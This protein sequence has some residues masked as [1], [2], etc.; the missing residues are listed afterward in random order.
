MIIRDK[1]EL[2]TCKKLYETLNNFFSSFS[3]KNFNVN[4]IAI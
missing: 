1:H 3:F 4:F 2:L